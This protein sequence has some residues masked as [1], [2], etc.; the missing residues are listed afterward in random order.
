ML[1]T[2]AEAEGIRS[3]LLGARSQV[4]TTRPDFG[5]ALWATWPSEEGMSQ[6]TAAKL[7]DLALAA[8]PDTEW[9]CSIAAAGKG[10]GEE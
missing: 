5:L 8:G 4:W 1:D 7:R 3:I 6:Q 2:A 10:Q 9:R